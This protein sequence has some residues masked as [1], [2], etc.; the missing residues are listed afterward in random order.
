MFIRKKNLEEIAKENA[1]LN[2]E[3]WD[4]KI[5][6]TTFRDTEA[7][8]NNQINELKRKLKTSK[9]ESNTKEIKN[10]ERNLTILRNTLLSIKK[11]C[12]KHKQSEVAKAILNEIKLEDK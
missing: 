5:E 10:L 1:K 4:L 12:E 9:K 2:S 11:Y 7:Y 3:N 6:K 8:L